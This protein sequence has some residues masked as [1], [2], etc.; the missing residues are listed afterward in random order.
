MPLTHGWLDS[1]CAATPGELL[2]RMAG[3]ATTTQVESVLAGKD[4]SEVP[5]SIV[6]AP[7][8][9]FRSTQPKPSY[10]LLPD[11]AHCAVRAR[12]MY[13]V[14]GFFAPTLASSLAAKSADNKQPDELQSSQL[15]K[16]AYVVATW[17]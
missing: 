14:G 13:P 9:L 12:Y 4:S 8:S 16:D 10:L 1:P 2:Q 5:P 17:A 15:Q 11:S 6:L 3:V 7:M